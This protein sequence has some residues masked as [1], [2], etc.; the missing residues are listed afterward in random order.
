MDTS[1][2]LR[3]SRSITTTMP[4]RK[5]SDEKVGYPIGVVARLTS[6]HPET[7]RIW[8]RRYGIVSPER[9]GRGNRLYSQDDVRRLALV[10]ALVE[11]GHPVSIVARLSIAHLEE[12]IKATAPRPPEA[13]AQAAGPCRV[14]VVGDVLAARLA[15]GG[16]APHDL[17]IVGTFPDVTRLGRDVSKPAADVLLLEHPSVHRETASDVRRQLV[18]SGAARAVVIYAFGPRQALRE[19]EAAGVVSLRAPASVVDIQRAC[20]AS[21]SVPA[22]RVPLELPA[23]ESVPPRRYSA[24]QLASIAVSASRVACECPH[25][26]ADLIN[27]LAAFETYSR[28]CGSRNAED[29]AVHAFLYAAAGTARALLETGLERVIAL[30]GSS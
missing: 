6:I 25:H 28:E 24:E 23:P 5:H 14:I 1:D 11:A 21:R 16:P 8:E 15:A 19:L 13:A 3:L 10:K 18:L 2:A 7:L 22:A 27:S 20:L 29:A 17:K 9:T 4:S 26:L 30:E 12:R